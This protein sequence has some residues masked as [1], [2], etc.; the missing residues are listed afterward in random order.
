MAGIEIIT[1]ERGSELK[2]F[3]ELP[4]K[5]YVAYPKW[6]P[7]LKK[8]VRRML[9]PLNHPFWEFSQRILF[10]A[11]RGKETV[12]RIAGI[13]DDRYNQFHNEKMGIW[14]FFECAD[15]P[16][17]A[18]ALFSSV[19]AWVHNKGMTF[20]RGPLNPSTNHE[21][22]LLIEGFDYP[23]SLM[24]TYNPPYYA[25]LI[26]SCGYCKEKDLLAFLIDSNY[27]L[28][29]W[30]DRLADKVAKKKGVHIRHFRPKD[31][32]AEFVLIR[33]I[34]NDAWADNWGFVPVTEKEMQDIQKNVMEFA[35]PDMAFFIYYEEEP[36]AFCLVFPDIN[37]LL[38]RLDGRVGLL[39]LLKYF[40]YKKEIIGL[41]LFMFGIKEKY[42][43]LGFPML[44]FHHI[45]EIVRKKEKY[46]YMEMGWTLEDNEAINEL[47]EEAGAKKY[48]K[49]RIFRKS[50][51]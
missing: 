49:Y 37:P 9:D 26:E 15:D 5:I 32:D 41:R 50:L 17:A 2:D 3:I 28:P 7:P 10:L 11:R 47:I 16:Q 25:G 4:W 23:P 48:K 46:Q 43:Q 18:A 8:E 12:G 51:S 33:Q 39:G 21:A 24:M 45:Y 6:V 22:G 34:Y 38:K 1:V 42:R 13:I 29:G 31:A 14:G 40:L 20:I 19:E 27:K 35:D 44:A 30:M 36:A